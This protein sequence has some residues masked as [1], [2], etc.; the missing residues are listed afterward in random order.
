MVDSRGNSAIVNMVIAAPPLV[1]RRNYREVVELPGYE[2]CGEE[3]WFSPQFEACMV[4][5]GAC[6]QDMYDL[7]ENG[8]TWESLGGCEGIVCPR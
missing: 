6:I 2:V 3:C 5:Q 7:D 1:L 4:E 8:D